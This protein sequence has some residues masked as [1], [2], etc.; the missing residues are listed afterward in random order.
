MKATLARSGQRQACGHRVRQ[1]AVIVRVGRRWLCAACSTPGG[2]TAAPPQC[3]ACGEPMGATSQQVA[4]SP[5]RGWVH[6]ACITDADRAAWDAAAAAI[7]NSI[8]RTKTM[9]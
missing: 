2:T 8:E 3:P 6:E 4:L 1:G 5:R 9:A 7:R